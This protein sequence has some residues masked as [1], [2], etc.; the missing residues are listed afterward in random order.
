MHQLVSANCNGT[1]RCAYANVH[2]PTSTNVSCVCA[3]TQFQQ[4]AAQCLK[5]NCTA[6]DQATALALQSKECN[7]RYL[8]LFTYLH[9]LMSFFLWYSDFQQLCFKHRH[10][11]CFRSYLQGCRNGQQ[12]LGIWRTYRSCCCGGRSYLWRWTCLLKPLFMFLGR[13]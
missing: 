1:L 3:S 10:L 11:A 2:T 8:Y 13:W 4:A 6:A 12:S 9:A 5:A 7:S